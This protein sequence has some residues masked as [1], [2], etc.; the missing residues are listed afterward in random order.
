MRRFPENRAAS[1]TRRSL[2]KRGAA[3]S[4]LALLAGRRPLAA[5]ARQAQDPPRIGIVGAGIAGLSAAL[6]LH[7]AGYATAILE[8]ADRVGGRMHSNTVTWADNQTSE[9]CGEF[10]DTAHISIRALADRFRLPLVDLLADVAPDAQTTRFF[11]GRYYSAADADRDLPPVATVVQ[12]QLAA[13]GPIARYDTVTPDAAFFD[14]MSVA[15]WIDVYIPG[16][17]GSPPG[18]CSEVGRCVRLPRWTPRLI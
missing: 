9:W 6:T 5:R 18:I 17:L 1:L 10:I 13:I 7:D 4:S 16:G 11:L 8:A 14:R 15:R 12:E 3:A 2:L